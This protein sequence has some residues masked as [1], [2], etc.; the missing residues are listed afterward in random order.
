MAA[1][2][3]SLCAPLSLSR[4]FSIELAA[5]AFNVFE[6]F[7]GPNPDSAKGRAEAQT[8]FRQFVFDFW[9]HDS[10]HGIRRSGALVVG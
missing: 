2:Q 3:R 5:G 7:R 6:V 8:K 4:F 1:A 9:R 10:M